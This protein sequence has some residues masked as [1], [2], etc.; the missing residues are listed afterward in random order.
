MLSDTPANT[1]LEARREHYQ[2]NKNKFLSK[3]EYAHLRSLVRHSKSRAAILLKLYMFTAARANEG[4]AVRLRDLDKHDKTVYIKGLKGSN[5]REVPLPPWYFRE[6]MSYAKVVCKSPEDRIFPFT[7]WILYQTWNE[8]RPCD[9]TIHSLRHTL[10]I[11]V[12]EGTRDI[13]L[14]QTLLGHRT[15]K[16]TMVYLDYIYSRD[17]MKRILK[18]KY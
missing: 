13:K 6:L 17:E 12:Y 9:K 11:K 16:N 2:I 15:I 4:L 8:H 14:V 10:A 5:D 3:A 1:D 7:Y 18:V